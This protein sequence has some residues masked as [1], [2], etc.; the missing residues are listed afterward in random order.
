[1]KYVDQTII[2]NFFNDSKNHPDENLR[3]QI[4][5]PL[6]TFFWSFFKIVFGITE[7]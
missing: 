4:K 7:K 6:R 1:M 5:V 2:Y 3:N